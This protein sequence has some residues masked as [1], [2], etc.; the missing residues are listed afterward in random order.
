MVLG[1][2]SRDPLYDYKPLLKEIRATGCRWVSLQCNFYQE[3]F[4]SVD[5]PV[6]DPRTP[7]WSRVVWTIR[8]AHALGLRVMLFPVLLLQKPDEDHWRGTIEPTDRAEWHQHYR[9]WIADAAEIAEREGVEVFSIGSEF[10]SMQRDTEEWRAHIARARSIYRG[11]LTYSVNWDTMNEPAFFAE[12]DFVGM[13]TYFSLTDRNDPSVEALREAWQPIRTDILEWQ[14]YHG[15]P[16]LFTEVG[17]ASQDGINTNPWNYFISDRVDLQEQYDCF[18]AFGDV[19]LEEPGL[20]GF[21]CYNWF[22]V[23]GAEDTGYTPRGK[24]VMALLRRWFQG[25]ETP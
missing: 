9:R 12:L 7:P 19:W 23:G 21:F 6:D 20:A 17:F 25:G 15:I 18:Q 10:N 24:P 14:A 4:D 3:R 16:L 5:F 8:D 2:F 1:L 11:A 22:G 13:T